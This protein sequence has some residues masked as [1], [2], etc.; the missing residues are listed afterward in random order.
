MEYYEGCQ[1]LLFL[2][3]LQNTSSAKSDT[4]FEQGK[5]T[6]AHIT[7]NIWT[8]RSASA[9]Q[10]KGVSAKWKILWTSDNVISFKSVLR[11]H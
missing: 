8:Y 3:M 11:T 4:Y 6:N 1:I 9:G 7:H 10:K 5:L 2:N